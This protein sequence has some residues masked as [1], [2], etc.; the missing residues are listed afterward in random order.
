MNVELKH[1][2]KKR[3]GLFAV[4][5]SIAFLLY[6]YYFVGIT[7]VALVIRQI[8]IFYFSLALMAVLMSVLF[9]SLTWYDLLNNLSVKVKIRKVFLFVWVGMFFDVIVPDPG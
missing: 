1:F 2:S 9:S 3:I 6:L 8:N 5:G 7:D 4:L